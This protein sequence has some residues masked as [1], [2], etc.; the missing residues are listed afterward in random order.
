MKTFWSF[1][2]G[3]P[4]ALTALLLAVGFAAP[5]AAAPGVHKTDEPVTFSVQNGALDP[6]L[7]FELVNRTR[8]HNGLAELR[9]SRLLG[10]VAAE[11]AAD[12]STRQYYAHQSPDGTY[13]YDKFAGHGITAGYSCENLD[14]TFVPNQERVI[15]EWMSS[16][17]GHRNCMLSPEVTHA[18]Y[19][20][21]QL[22]LVQYDGS[23]TTAYL[24]VAIHASL[25]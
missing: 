22:N 1:Y 16:S 5:S 14:L 4:F 11:R 3:L 8:K 24:V 19:A 9:A 25:E 7:T 15:Y 10:A 13:Y 18:G 6:N 2:A 20:S 23:I 17:Q 21:T 12:M